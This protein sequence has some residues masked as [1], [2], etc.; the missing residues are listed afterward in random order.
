MT[1][2]KIAFDVDGT[3]RCNCTDTCQHPNEEIVVLF[4]ILSKFKNVILFV[5]SGG[6]KDY[7]QNFAEKYDLP[8]NPKFCIGKINAPQM[9]IAIDDQHEFSLATLNLI[10]RNK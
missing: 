1:K 6:G 10:A 7:A 3:L 9:D 4:K 5:W 2:I 8:V